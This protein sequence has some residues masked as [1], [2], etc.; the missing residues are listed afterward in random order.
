MD[1]PPEV[2][3]AAPLESVTET[4][5]LVLLPVEASVTGLALAPPMPST[6]GTA[7]PEGT[8]AG[9]RTFT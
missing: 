8:L 4:A 1:T 9:T 2:T 3:V 5:E 6:T 7:L